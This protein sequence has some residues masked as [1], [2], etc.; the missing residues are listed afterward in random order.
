VFIFYYLLF[1]DGSFVDV[2][3]VLVT[4]DTEV[5]CAAAGCAADDSSNDYENVDNNSSDTDA[6]DFHN[7]NNTYRPDNIPG[8]LFYSLTSERKR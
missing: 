8:L 2:V 1:L 5:S 4:D 7:S 6:T 3:V